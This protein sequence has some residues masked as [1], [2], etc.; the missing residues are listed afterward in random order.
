MERS[1]ERKEKETI[2]VYWTLRIRIFLWDFCF[3]T[4][5]VP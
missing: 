3:R 2:R 5:Y 1:E 4:T